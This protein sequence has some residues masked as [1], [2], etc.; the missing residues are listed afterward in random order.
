M[1]MHSQQAPTMTTMAM[2]M[3]TM[4]TTTI[5]VWLAGKAWLDLSALV[6]TATATTTAAGMTATTTTATSCTESTMT[7]RTTRQTGLVGLWRETTVVVVV[8]ERVETKRAVAERVE[9][10]QEEVLIYSPVG[11][12][13]ADPLVIVVS[14]AYCNNS[15]MQMSLVVPVVLVVAGATAMATTVPMA[16]VVGTTTA[17]TRTTKTTRRARMVKILLT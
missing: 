10:S 6:V 14:V 11:E 4:N 2:M 8:A 13:T 17:T 5:K 9:A 15:T 7:L 16:L 12:G 1:C 3:L